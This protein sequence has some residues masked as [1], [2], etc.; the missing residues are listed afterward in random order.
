MEGTKSPLLSPG[1][2][3][4]GLRHAVS[5]T[6]LD[7]PPQ[8]LARPKL[9]KSWSFHSTSD[10]QFKDVKVD[11]L[12]NQSV[13]APF[14][15]EMISDQNEVIGG[16]LRGTITLL[17]G[18]AYPTAALPPV[19]EVD[20]EKLENENTVAC[21]N[22]EAM[23]NLLNNCL[24]SGMLGMGF[25]IAQTGLLGGFLIMIFSAFLNRYTLMLNIKSCKYAGCKPASTEVG[26][27]AY[28]TPGRLLLV[29]MVVLLGFFCMVSYVDASAD[30]VAGL[31]RTFMTEGAVPSQKSIAVLCWLVLLVPPTL[32]RSM[33]LVAMLS[34]MAFIGS[35]VIILSVSIVCLQIL[36]VEGLPPIDQVRLFPESVSGLLTAFPILMLVFS[37]Q[38][39]GD[40][41]L[42]TM[43]DTSTKNMYKVLDA[44]YILVF[45]M[46]YFIGSLCYL[47][48][49]DDMKGDVLQNF[50]S[51]STAG[52]IARIA[53]LDLVVL[54]YM[55]MIIP[56]KVS[57]IDLIFGKN[58]ALQESTLTQFYGTTMVLNVLALLAALLVSDLSLVL[59]ING[60]VCT[61]FVAFML[62]SAFWLKVQSKPADPSLDAVAMFSPHNGKDATVCVLGAISLVLS[63]YQVMQRASGN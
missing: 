24:G 50:S 11:E 17:T 46:L 4:N 62:P 35:I 30:A 60:A 19:D 47:T 3:K 45:F 57:L 58:E 39:G 48:W 5:T 63:S 1:L 27:I 40:V 28:G 12:L 32:I 43:K 26:S 31:L 37:V 23:L 41:V 18:V 16:M 14:T 38:A 8:P 21:T 61:N 15:V 51:T 10:L 54:S 22:G 34:F 2:K 6:Q 55:I 29:C 20:E 53:S 33:S 56:C 49:L 7:T 25:C 42:V 9:Q 59:G 52:V 13:A 36:I 44:S